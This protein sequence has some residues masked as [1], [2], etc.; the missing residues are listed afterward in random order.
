MTLVYRHF[1][2]VNKNVKCIIINIILV[3]LLPVYSNTNCNIYIYITFTDVDCD[4]KIFR[5]Y[6][7]TD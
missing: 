7:S 5:N 2:E 3:G 6:G 1:T 4:L